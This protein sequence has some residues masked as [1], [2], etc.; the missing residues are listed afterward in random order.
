MVTGT[1]EG[2]IVMSKAL[3]EPAV[4]GN[5]LLLLRSYIKLL[6]SPAVNQGFREKVGFLV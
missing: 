5:L 4:L 3:K 2:G 1:V 6:F